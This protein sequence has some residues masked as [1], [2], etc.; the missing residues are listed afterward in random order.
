MTTTSFATLDPSLW[1]Q[2][3]D[4]IAHLVWM[5]G[6]DGRSAWFNRRC[7]EF[8]GV[9]NEALQARGWLEFIHPEDSARVIAEWESAVA[10]ARPYEAVYR[11]RGKDG[12]YRRFLARAEPSFDPD[13]TVRCWFGTSTDISVQVEAEERAQRSAERLAKAAQLA[14]MFV[15]ESDRVTRTTS[16]GENAAE[17]LDVPAEELPTG[18]NGGTFF[19]DEAEKHRLVAAVEE[20]VAHR[21]QQLT[22]DFRG[23]DGRHWR[24]HCGFVY[25]PDGRLQR[26]YGATRDVSAEAADQRR[27]AYLLRLDAALRATDAA[28]DAKRVAAET[29]SRE[30]GADRVLYADVVALDPAT[31]RIE[32]EY[33]GDGVASI[34][35]THHVPAPIAALHARGEPVVTS[36]FRADP[37]LVSAAADP[38]VS[39]LP[40]VALIDIPL[41]RE[42]K[43][44]GMLTVH[45]LEQRRWTA[46]EVALA[47]LT[48]ERTWEAVERA[49]AEEQQRLTADEIA[50]TY[51]TAPIGLAVVDHQLRYVRVNQRLAEMNGIPAADHIGKTLG[52]VVPDL[53]GALGQAIKRALAGEEV[54]GFEVSG[55]TASAPGVVRTWRENWLPIRDADGKVTGA[56]G[57]IEEIASAE[58]LRAEAEERYRTIF[59]SA[60]VGIARVAPDGAFLEVN[61]RLC[62]IVGRSREAILQGGW[63]D[64]THPDDLAAD[65]AQVERALAGEIDSYRLEKRYLDAEGKP[66]WINLTVSTERNSDRSVRYFISI[67]E[68]ITER[69][70]REDALRTSEQR[71]RVANDHAEVGFWDVDVVND[72]LTWS[73]HVRMMFGVS[74]DVPVTLADFY[75]GLHPEDREHTVAAYLAAADPA[76]QALY[77]VEYRTIG[78]NDGVVRWVAAKGRGI[79]S[80]DGRCLQVVGT[81]ID[82]TQRKEAEDALRRS[83][84]ELR[85]RLNAIPQM[86]WSTRP[87]GYHDFYNERWYEFTGMPAGTTDGEEWNGMFHPDDQEQAW[88]RWRQSLATAEPYEIEYRLRH[89]SGDYRWVLGRA[90]PIL[91]SAGE[92][93]RWMGTCTD[94]DDRKAAERALLENEAQ[95]RAILEAVP[96]GLMF[97]DASGQLTGGNDQIIEFL[98]HDLVPSANEQTYGEDYVAFH[99][100]GRR[101][102]SHEYPLARALAGEERP[103]LECRVRRGDGSLRWLRYV[104]ASVRGPA[105]EI[106]GGVVASID[107][108]REKQLTEGLER[109]VEKV[110]TEREA[111]QEA[112]RQSQKL[113]AMGQLTGGVAH[114][115]NNLLTPIIGS[116]DLLQRKQILDERT[117]RLVDGAL[118]SAEKARVLVQRLLA[119][120]RRQPLQTQAIDIGRIVTEM[121]EL[122]D[123]TSGPRVR[124]R[125]EVPADLPP[126]LADSNQLEMALLN[127]SV[128]ARDAMPDGGTLTIATRASGGGEGAKLGLTGERHVV[129]SVSDTGVGMDEETRR[130]AIEPFFST[131][132]IGKGTGLGLSMVHGL[133]AQLGGALDIRSVPGMG[134]TIELWLPMASGGIAAGVADAPDAEVQGAGTAL[135]VDDDELVRASTSGML[136]DLGYRVIEADSGEAALAL[137]EKGE[138]FDLLVTD[139]LMP[140]ISGTDLAVQLRQRREDLPVLIVSGY[141]D[142]ESL[143]PAFPHLSKPFRQAELATALE[144]VQPD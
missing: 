105:G 85:L 3:A 47:T 60:A 71:V 26:V 123:S 83:E 32:A 117:G 36:D 102:E 141:A 20:A 128:N 75:D 67:I 138:R 57:S 78:K 19:V 91:D 24:G 81:A 66:V 130:R 142:L 33:L 115:F 9:S 29:L 120:A 86:V 27:N 119:F 116:L 28:L 133:A 21:R 72:T 30:L 16:W 90:L 59:N 11:I 129:L 22:I 15:W 93:R 103:E 61:D 96:V 6:G 87:D 137:I 1:Q 76:R 50:V 104:A 58:R 97:S 127:L 109:E 40:L 114:D 65:L 14:D 118:T 48:A 106:A 38:A 7:T 80:D 5:A 45:M 101:V 126:A 84:Q 52:E 88:A 8:T 17:V 46:E 23:S 51:S 54:R 2:L 53:S 112:L 121:S 4:H 37:A 42:G 143:S 12:I 100:D 31:L 41:L 139:Q 95:L 79:F 34:A 132:G 98:G 74:P 82:V 131:K 55:E 108:D 13:G 70:Q 77:D 63:R 89:H 56:A 44:V 124:V 62:E 110:I 94:I 134:T 10:A 92:V 113:E 68:D 125:T 140:G 144:K 35:G 136:G 107:I 64:L 25:D 111:A 122:I 69:R 43:L 135:L 99:A 18:P 39:D 73:P 49:R